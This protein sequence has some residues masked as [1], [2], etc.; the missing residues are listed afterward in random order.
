MS[1]KHLTTDEAGVLVPID[2]SADNTIALAQFADSRD[3]EGNQTGRVICSW[4]GV[5][6]GFDGTIALHL[7]FPAAQSS[8]ILAPVNHQPIIVDTVAVDSA[9]GYA[10]FPLTAPIEFY[11]IVYTHG[12]IDAG[13][14]LESVQINK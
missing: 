14:L 7:I 13:D 1:Y 5:G 11:Q 4:T 6:A 3:S 8:T 9:A 10:D 12:T 2:M